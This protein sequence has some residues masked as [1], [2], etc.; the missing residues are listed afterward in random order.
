MA[1]GP[2]VAAEIKVGDR[3]IF[4]RYAAVILDGN[5]RLI[6]DKDILAKVTDEN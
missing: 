4:N 3:I 6:T 1:C 2:T 5:G